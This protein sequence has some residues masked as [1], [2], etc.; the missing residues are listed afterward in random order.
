MATDLSALCDRALIRAALLA[1]AW[2]SELTVVACRGDAAVR[3]VP[4]S[5]SSPG[6]RRG[7]IASRPEH[8]HPQTLLFDYVASA[9]VDLIVF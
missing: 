3:I 9:D 6:A 8:G 5:G 7:R 2:L 1:R 4:G